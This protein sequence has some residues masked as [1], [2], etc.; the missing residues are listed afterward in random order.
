[1]AKIADTKITYDITA[2][3]CWECTSHSL[4]KDGYPMIKGMTASRYVYKKK[5]GDIPADIVIRHKCDN[6]KCINPDHLEIGT[7]QENIIDISTRKRWPDRSGSKNG[8]AKLNEELILEI[9]RR[10]RNFEKQS[11]IAIS[12]GV[13]QQIISRIKTGKAWKCVERISI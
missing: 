3:G 11:D 10:L 6:R 4:N 1:M 13:S 9:I 2:N 7:Q 8:C 12:L 5:Y